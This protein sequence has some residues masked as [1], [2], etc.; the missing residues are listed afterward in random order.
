MNCTNSDPV[1]NRPPEPYNHY[2]SMKQ[3]HPIKPEQKP[4]QRVFDQDEIFLFT[5]SNNIFLLKVFYN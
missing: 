3:V 2:G 4:Q 5:S 1:T